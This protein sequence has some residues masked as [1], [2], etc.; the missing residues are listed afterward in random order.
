[1]G[2]THDLGANED[3]ASRETLAGSTDRR[4]ASHHGRA[5]TLDPRTASSR[6]D[7]AGDLRP[8]EHRQGADRQRRGD[9]AADL[10]ADRAP[11]GQ[12]A[13]GDSRTV[14]SVAGGRRVGAVAT[15]EGVKLGRKRTLPLWEAAI[16]TNAA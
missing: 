16:N 7:P 14:P 5:R 6:R 3:C 12:A 15:V 1:M 2:T 9:V 10:T 8:A 13:A 4:G 11:H